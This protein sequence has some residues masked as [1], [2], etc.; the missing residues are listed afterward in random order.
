M[1]SSKSAAT[2]NSSGKV[3]VVLVK[4]VVN[5]SLADQDDLHVER[6]R[7]RLE[8]HSADQAEGFAEGFDAHLARLQ[9]TFERFPSEGLLQ[10][11]QRLDD[12]ISA[13]GAMQR[14]A[15]N[16]V[17]VGDQGAQSRLVLGAADQV[18]IGRIVLEDD[19]SAG[20]LAVVDQ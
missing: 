12:Q 11:A 1:R 7:L 3:G 15:A 16:Q 18:R 5:E 8:R 10:Q 9:R 13:V 4:Q 20:G 14:A 6:D 2:L 19:R 17:E